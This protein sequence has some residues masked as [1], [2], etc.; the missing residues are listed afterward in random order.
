MERIVYYDKK[1]R[2]ELEKNISRIIIG[3]SFKYI[4]TFAHK[5]KYVTDIDISNFIY[6]KSCETF[7]HHILKSIRNI[8]ETEL[9]ENMKLLYLTT[10]FHPDLLPSWRLMAKDKIEN[11]NYDE[12]KKMLDL[13]IKYKKIDSTTYSTFIKLAKE[14]TIKTLILLEDLLDKKSRISWKPNEILVGKKSMLGKTFY[15]KETL[16]SIPLK[17]FFRFMWKYEDVYIL[18]DVSMYY[19]GDLDCIFKDWTPPKA[20]NWDRDKRLFLMYYGK[21][22]YWLLRETRYLFKQLQRQGLLDLNKFEM[23]FNSIIDITE[24]KVGKHKF[25]YNKLLDYYKIIRNSDIEK[26]VLKELIVTTLNDII[27]HVNDGNI[28]DTCEKFIQSYHIY[29]NKQIIKNLKNIS[30]LINKHLN[31]MMFDEMKKYYSILF[32]IDPTIHDRVP[33]IL[34]MKK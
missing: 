7:Q 27:E 16:F 19:K 5:M 24:T 30:S 25:F 6:S 26:N 12:T 13:L 8:V 15:L 11:Y 20:S 32:N 2:R 33:P 23:Y 10:G 17:N 1:I 14:P 29:D 31:D 34:D 28:V 21:E 3:K 4:G 9:P 18:I 22:Y